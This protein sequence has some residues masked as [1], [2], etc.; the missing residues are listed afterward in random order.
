M[1]V[2]MAMLIHN[3]P[4]STRTT[5]NSIAHFF[6][7]LFGYL[8]GPFVYGLVYDMTGGKDS[9]WGMFALECAGMLAVI[10]MIFL[11]IRQKRIEA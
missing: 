8:P 1:P 10:I 11:W 2:L 7:N 5:A 4:P 9:I 3:V 6:Y